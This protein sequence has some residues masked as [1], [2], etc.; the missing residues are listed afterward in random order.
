MKSRN[1]FNDKINNNIKTEGNIH[2]KST[3]NINNSFY[4]ENLEINKNDS[5]R[6]NNNF[7][8]K[9]LYKDIP[10][11][12]KS[13]NIYMYYKDGVSVTRGEKLKFL[14]T[15]Y[16]INL[17]KPLETQKAL[18]LKFYNNIE[19]KKEKLSKKFSI[20]HYNLDILNRNNQKLIKDMNC[21]QNDLCDKI[22]NEF[23]YFY[24]SINDKKFNDII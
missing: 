3:S 9:K 15:T 18:K 20:N 17:I 10:N 7:D 13:K 2:S 4:T 6:L 5:K 23:T 8:L 12:E 11:Y 19:I 1:T 24:N 16:P 21:I 22:K 14:K